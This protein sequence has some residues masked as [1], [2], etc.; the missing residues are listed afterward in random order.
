M[1][2]ETKQTTALE[3]IVRY[4]QFIVVAVGL[5]VGWTIFESRLNLVE[6]KYSNLSQDVIENRKE[7]DQ[8][9]KESLQRLS[10][11][12][13]KVDFLVGSN[14]AQSLK[15]D[16]DKG[17][18]VKNTVNINNPKPSVVVV[19]SK[20]T[21]QTPTTVQQ[22]TTDTSSNMITLKPSNAVANPT[23]AQWLAENPGKTLEDYFK[24]Y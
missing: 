5:V 12:E 23:A 9:Q 7:N 20:S 18:V 8:Y 19:Q 17:I 1:K 10:S 2:S 22:T 14:N 13:A 3:V 21:T 4:W 6:E 24:I 16:N 15:S 11:I